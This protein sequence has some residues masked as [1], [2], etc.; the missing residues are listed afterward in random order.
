MAARLSAI[1]VTVIVGATLIAGLIVGAQRYDADGPVDL[2]IHNARVY[3]GEGTD[4]AEAVAVRGNQVLL[5]GSNREVRRLRRP[6]TTMI[7]AE[8]GTVVPGFNDTQ[9][10]LIQGGLSRQ[11]AIDAS[12][13]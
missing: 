10:S 4:M 1:I 12:G 5:V 2:I 6:Q 13:A 9:V 8:G 11:D 7:D 3:T